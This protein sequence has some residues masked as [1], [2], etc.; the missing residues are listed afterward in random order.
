MDRNK[1]VKIKPSSKDIESFFSEN[2]SDFFR[3]FNKRKFNII[4]NHV[5]TSLYLYDGVVMGYGHIDN[6]DNKNWLGI[7]ISDKYRNK[8]MGS[9]IMEDLLKESID[10]IYLTVDKENINAIHLYNKIGFTIEKE[11]NNHYLMIYK[12]NKKYG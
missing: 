12:K 7:F 6:E 5:Y 2:K 4:E 11:E 9:I 8:G 3:Y 10:N 1:L